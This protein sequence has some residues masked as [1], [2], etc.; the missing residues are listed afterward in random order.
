MM[1]NRFIK[2]KISI[3]KGLILKNDYV[4]NWEVYKPLKI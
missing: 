1:I 4:L 3:F 2:L